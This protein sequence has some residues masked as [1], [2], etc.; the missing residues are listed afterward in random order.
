MLATRARTRPVFCIN[1]YPFRKTFLETG[2][3]SV[4]FSK[5]FWIPIIMET[6]NVVLTFESV[7]KLLWCDHSN[8]TFFAFLLHGTICFSIFCRMKFETFL[9]F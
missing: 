7:D 1:K 8:E 3:S 6:C 5:H 2:V 9:K 4:P